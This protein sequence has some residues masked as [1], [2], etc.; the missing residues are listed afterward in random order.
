MLMIHFVPWGIWTGAKIEAVGVHFK[1][2][3]LDYLP[4]LRHRD[5]KPLKIVTH[6]AAVLGSWFPH[7]CR[8]QMDFTGASVSHAGKIRDLNKQEME[9]NVA[10]LQ[11][12]KGMVCHAHFLPLSAAPSSP[13]LN[14]D[15]FSQISWGEVGERCCSICVSKHL[16]V[17]LKLFTRKA[18]LDVELFLPSIEKEKDWIQKPHQWA[19]WCLLS[20]PHIGLNMAFLFLCQ[21]HV[22]R[23]P[24]FGLFTLWIFCP[25]RG[26]F[27]EQ[28]L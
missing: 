15:Y 12:P 26:T 14:T 10:E 22:E 19:L 5:G 25:I 11:E 16:R 27:E 8:R 20:A 6:R 23:P 7:F 1:S 28:E 9:I 4:T 17:S 18:A 24:R 21:L 2:P 13:W 3:G